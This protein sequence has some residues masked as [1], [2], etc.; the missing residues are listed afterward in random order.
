MS[1]PRRRACS[2]CTTEVIVE[3]ASLEAFVA[4][5]SC[6][7]SPC[8]RCEAW[9]DEGEL[10]V[11]EAWCCGAASEAE[12]RGEDEADEWSF[13]E[14][15]APA[16]EEI[17]VEWEAGNGVVWEAATVVKQEGSRAV[18]VEYLRDETDQGKIF[19]HGLKWDELSVDERLDAVAEFDEKAARECPWVRCVEGDNELL[20]D[21]VRGADRRWRFGEE[22]DNGKWEMREGAEELAKTWLR[23][24]TGT[25][26]KRNRPDDAALAVSVVAMAESAHFDA[27]FQFLEQ[28]ELPLL[29]RKNVVRPGSSSV[30]KGAN[31]GVTTVRASR[32]VALSH[33]FDL[34]DTIVAQALT[35]FLRAASGPDLPF[36]SVQINRYDC[37]DH[38]AALHVDRNNAGPS[39]IVALGSF[40]TGGQ[41]WTADQGL[42]DVRH[43]W[44]TFDG[45]QPHATMP[46][47]PATTTRYSLIYWCNQLAPELPAK[48]RRH[49]E[50]LGFQFPRNAD[51]QVL[52]TDTPTALGD[53]REQFRDFCQAAPG[54]PD[55]WAG[56]P[57]GV[58]GAP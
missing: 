33:G 44:A 29:R 52:H 54:V 19:V 8:G 23:N 34:R 15:Q 47:G 32:R 50:R 31:V 39:V 43:K 38:A 20:P 24:R 53:A 4:C 26:R 5:P 48:D 9:F 27:M 1:Y 18:T 41:L 14:R 16:L 37:D 25:T 10:L 55:D 58:V 13:W 49:A 11:H 12:A 30:P 3:E 42:L 21:L 2:R 56:V 57:T 35:A 51:L 6:G 45:R 17:E 40:R 36:T 7:A 28:I 46:F 22:Q